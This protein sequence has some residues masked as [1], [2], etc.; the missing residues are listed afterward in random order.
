[1]SIFWPHAAPATYAQMILGISYTTWDRFRDSRYPYERQWALIAKT[2]GLVHH[3]RF[4]T[5]RTR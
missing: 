5:G 3:D 2:R 4:L 1:M